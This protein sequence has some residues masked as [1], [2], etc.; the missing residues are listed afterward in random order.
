M[1]YMHLV[2][3]NISK[4]LLLPLGLVLDDRNSI[5]I[6]SH[7]HNLTLQFNKDEDQERE[8]VPSKKTELKTLF[9]GNKEN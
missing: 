3:I 6:M 9:G 4:N 5:S 7:S 2:C 8:I 1:T